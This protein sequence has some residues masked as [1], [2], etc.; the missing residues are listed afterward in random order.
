MGGAKR[1]N[2]C[3]VDQDIDVAVAKLDRAFGN[4]TCARSVAKVGRNK[5]RLPA[6]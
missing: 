4:V 2:A 1:I 5:V 6:G 3:I